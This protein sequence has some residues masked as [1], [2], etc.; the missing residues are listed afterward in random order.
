MFP[1]KRLSKASLPISLGALWVLLGLLATL[2]YRW[3]GELS[4]AE[5]ARMRAGAKASA[6]SF[7]R[8]F[9]REV[10]R[11]FLLLQLDP[12]SLRTRDFAAFAGRYE[13]W[14]RSTPHSGLV[15]NVFLIETEPDA[16]L[17]LSRFPRL[18]TLLSRAVRRGGTG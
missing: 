7:G 6:E 12:E 14:R 1:A 15:S 2:Q 4:H 16:V 18:R 10:T 11:A 3:A 9:D 5:R 13:K 17:R 8:D